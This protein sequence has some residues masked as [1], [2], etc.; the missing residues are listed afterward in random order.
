M[1]LNKAS[2]CT[3]LLV[4]VLM[5]GCLSREC[6]TSNTFLQQ[7]QINSTP[8]NLE[9][10]R[11][12]NSSDSNSVSYYFSDYRKIDGVDYILVEV[13]GNEGCALGRF[14][15]KEA[16]GL[17]PLIE[18]EGKGYGGAELKG[19]TF[20]IDGNSEPMPLVFTG[21]SSVID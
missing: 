6:N 21:V 10:A 11:M 1:L 20:T 5:V 9:V 14:T 8:Y 16:G 12:V 15:V 2:I 7:A 18:T 13:H 17:A 3:S 19:F 4:A